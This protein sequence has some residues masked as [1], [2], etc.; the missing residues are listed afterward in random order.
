MMSLHGVFVTQELMVSTKTWNALKPA[1]ATSKMSTTTYN[2][3]KNI[4]SHSQ[5]I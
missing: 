3:L 5:T 2:H 1:T 4:Y